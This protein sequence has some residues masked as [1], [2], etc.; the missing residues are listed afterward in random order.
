[1]SLS[2]GSSSDVN[3]K[4]EAWGIY[5]EILECMDDNEKVRM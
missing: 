2:A 3:S 1:M 5:Q 4:E